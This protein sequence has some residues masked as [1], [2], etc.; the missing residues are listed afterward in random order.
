MSCRD[1]ELVL[2]TWQLRASLLP[3]VSPSGWTTT[4]RLRAAVCLAV[5]CVVD[6]VERID[7]FEGPA[8]ERERF[9]ATVTA[10][11]IDHEQVRVVT[12]VSG[13][14]ADASEGVETSDARGDDFEETTEQFD[15]DEA[16]DR[17]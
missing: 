11:S 1:V 16:L 8:T 10:A 3:R 12:P 14:D 13:A 4:D 6:G 5:P 2:E 15:L 17:L 9:D 7:P